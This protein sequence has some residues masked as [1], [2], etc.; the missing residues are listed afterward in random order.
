VPVLAE[1]TSQHEVETLLGLCH[2]ST[3]RIYMAH[4]ND[5]EAHE[6]QARCEKASSGKL[7]LSLSGLF[8]W[9]L[10]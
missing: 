9:A 2:D 8:S 5:Q 10:L 6:F 1:L 3:M 4:G 7:V